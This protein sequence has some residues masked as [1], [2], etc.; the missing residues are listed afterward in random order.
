MGTFETFV[1]LM[2]AA[3]ILVGI[4]QKIHVPYPIA[5]I[6]GGTAIGFAPDIGIAF[7]PKSIL[8]MVLPPV[9]Y[10]S[11]F[12][13][14][15]R[16]FKHNWGVILSL[17]LGLVI[18]ST[19]V[20]GLIFKLIFPDI[21]WA[22]AFAFGAIVSPPDAIAATTILKRFSINSRILTILEGES[23]I[24]DAS[25]LVLYNLMVGA[26]LSGTFS[27]GNATAEFILKVSGGICVGVAVGLVLQKFSRR[28]LE[29]VAGVVFSFTIPYLTYIL[30][31]FLG[32]SGVLAVVVCGLI[33]SQI[34]LRHHSSLR[35]VLG[36]VSWDIFII[37]V[38]C[39]VFILIGLQLRSIISAK[40]INEM[41][42]YTGYGLLF[43]F[44]LIGVR[45]AWVYSKC[46]YD[47]FKALYRPNAAHVC[48]HILRES[49]LIGWMGMRGIVSLV[50]VLA[51][52]YS[53]P[54][55]SNLHGRDEVVFITFVVILS[56]LLIPGL[57]FKWL[58]HILRIQHQPEHN[59]I[60]K[61][62]K[63]LAKVAEDTIIEMHEKKT[64]G[65]KEK[66]FLL[67]Y[68]RMQIRV[69]EV[70]TSAHKKLQNLETARSL[71]I[72]EQRKK[73]F[74]IWE[75][76]EINDKLFSLLEHE[77]DLEETNIARAD[78]K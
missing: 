74:E 6:L 55:G 62:R 33:G 10:Y 69:L 37:L 72:K 54:D 45:M 27:F 9:L 35:R 15:F 70:S 60:L 66:G 38:N 73:L 23:L 25:A 71:V 32:Y 12:G 21:S 18:C 47:Y 52:P 39:F 1:L 40:T 17:A 53:L 3:A 59:N 67:E 50:A 65:D 31:E 2:F 48:S 22:L 34:L 64:I 20:V 76:L 5:L 51:L 61:I 11:S 77:L 29:P 44:V 8:V 68:F 75:K 58:T 26:I 24:N 14:S 56:S 46:G 13:I 7:D 57:S 41:L 43:T 4:S 19:I 28:Y 78:L 49:A 30:A 16:E 42:I 63:Q 36:F